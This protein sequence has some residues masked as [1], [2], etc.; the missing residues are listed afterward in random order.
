MSFLP[1]I[2][3]GEQQLLAAFAGQQYSQLRAA[4]HGLD[5]DQLRTRSTVSSLSIGELLRHT[6]RVASGYGALIAAAPEPGPVED[7]ADESM[8]ADM[9][10]EQLLAEFDS[11]VAEFDAL[12]TGEL[13]L[14]K[15][16]PIPKAPWFPEGNWEVRW[17]ILHVI[18]EV[19]RHAGHADIIRESIDG[20]GSYELNDLA[21]G[22]DTAAWA[23]QV[24]W[25]DSAWGG[26]DRT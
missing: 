12:L 19:A 5:A 16:V 9:T 13:D 18:A 11:S 8:P 4:A 14:A 21:D 22:V 6:A 20:K 2:V 24:G 26:A 10:V 7:P 15:P 23:E 25:D 1:P 17:V 3:T